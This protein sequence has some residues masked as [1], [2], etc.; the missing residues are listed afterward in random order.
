MTLVLSWRPPGERECHTKLRGH[1]AWT[2]TRVVST[3]NVVEKLSSVGYLIICSVAQV[4]SW[5]KIE[6]QSKEANRKMS[7]S[8]QKIIASKHRKRCSVWW[9]IREL[10][11]KTTMKFSCGNSKCCTKSLNNARIIK[12]FGCFWKKGHY[13]VNLKTD[14]HWCWTS[15]STP[16]YLSEGNDR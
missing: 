13:P 6:T 8:Q 4:H 11:I 1:T 15:S 16:R 2:N 14:S 10:Q 12:W 9:I 5:I 3:W 7:K